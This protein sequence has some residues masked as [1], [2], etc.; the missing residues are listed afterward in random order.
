MTK[1]YPNLFI[2]G[3]PK[4]GTTAWV[5]YLSSH[6]D[7]FFPDEKE[8]HYF[9]KD[10]PGFQ[11]SKTLEDYLEV[12]SKSA[13]EKVIGEASVQYL[14][15]KDAASEIYKYNP[16]AKIVIFLRNQDTFLP[17]YHQQLIYNQDQTISDFDKAWTES[18][19][20][21]LSKVSKTC[22][23]PKLLDYR[24]VGTFSEQVQ[25]YTD[26]FPRE[27]IKVIRFEAWVRES[28][29]TYLSLMDFLD[30]EDDGR[31]S[32][33]PVNEAKQHRFGRLAKIT[34]RPPAWMLS[35]STI[36]KKILGRENLGLASRLR[37]MN[38]VKGYAGTTADAVK[39]DIIEYFKAD[40]VKLSN[41]LAD[42]D[43]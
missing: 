11:W 4:C 43:G 34:Q 33:L 17:S 22:R 18:K 38:H 10:L 39:S 15:S 41:I 31:T 28:R 12:F 1:I 29:E 37:D 27:N 3:A 14:Y 23:E 19:D 26:L 42:F 21:Q 9:N 5:K 8:P 6:Q 13:N 30:L 32:F 7:I 40:N 2:V 25:R 36:I 20:F 24:S 35:M 16:N